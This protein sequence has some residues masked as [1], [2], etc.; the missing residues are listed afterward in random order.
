MSDTLHTR[1]AVPAD[2]PRL[3]RLD[4]DSWSRLSEVA[5]RPAPPTAASTLFDERH[6]PED[7][8]VAELDGEL[9]GY[10]RLVPPTPLPSNAHIRQI[11]GL[12][13]DR[14]ARRR[15]VG[16]ALVAAAVERARRIGARRVTLRVL[17][18]NTPART[19]YQVAGFAVEG[20]APE[21]F[22]LDGHYADD[23]L[24]GLTL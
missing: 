6:R 18:H 20:L 21:E 9:V 11:S 8:L 3:Y 2:G 22:Y 15:G 17:G 5:E 12:A 13:V 14:S 10:V 23:V 19:L 4:H 1:P 7:Y 16:A 24:M